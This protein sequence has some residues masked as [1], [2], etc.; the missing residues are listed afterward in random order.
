MIIN[1]DISQTNLHFKTGKS[2]CVLLVSQAYSMTRAYFNLLAS[3]N[4]FLI[5][6][7]YS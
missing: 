2:Y 3:A 4:F 7:E 5:I 6:K 1:S